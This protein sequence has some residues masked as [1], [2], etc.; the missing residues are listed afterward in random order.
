MLISTNSFLAQSDL[1]IENT[2]TVNTPTNSIPTDSRAKNLQTPPLVIKDSTQTVTVDTLDTEDSEPLE[3]PIEYNARDSIRYE[4]KGQKIFLFGDGRVKYDGMDMKAEF[5]EIDNEKN[6]LTAFGKTDSLGKETGTPVF[7]DGSQEVMA[8]KIVYNLKT[9]KGKIY[10][11]K[12]KEGELILKG[13]EVK[14]DSNNVVY[15]KN[16]ECIPCKF[17]DSRTIFKAKKAKIIPDDKIVTGP[18]YLEVGGVPTPLGLP[19]GFFPNTKKRHSG[20]LIPFYGNSDAL[21]FYLKDGGFYWGISDKTDMTIRGDIY[22]NGSWG[23]RTFNNYDI[24]YKSSG[25]VALGYSEFRSGEREIPS[26]YGKQKDISITWRHQ[27]DQKFN[28]TI[29]F[30]SDVNIRT[31]R[32]NKYNALNTGQYLT[33]TFQ[34]N[35]NFS[36]T[37]KVGVLSLNAR[38]DQNTQTKR[39]NIS[40][41]E[42]T[43]NVNRFYPFKNEKRIKQNPID[44]IGMSYLLEARNTLSGADTSIFKGNIGDSL[45]Y[46]FRHTLPISTNITLLKYFTLTPALNLSAVMYTKTTQKELDVANNRI[47]SSTN[48]NFKTGYDANFNSSLSTKLFMD[49]IFKSKQVKQ[50]RH[51]LIPTLAYTY[52]PDFGEQQYGFWKDVIT[53]TVNKLKTRY[54]IF[55]N[56]L[57]GGPGI[58]EQ[59]TLSLNLNNN[60]EAKVRK[61]TDT[62][63]VYQKITLLQ[64]LTF[65]GSYNFAA[66]SFNLSNISMTG[67]TKIWKYFDLVFGSTFDP[68][69]STILTNTLTNTEYAYRS[70]QYS[71]NVNGKLLNFYSGNIA[72]NASFSS[73]NLTMRQ[74]KPDLTNGAERQATPTNTLQAQEKLPWTLNIY[75]NINYTKVL[76]KIKDIQTLNFSGDI[77]VT[78]YWKL[79][80]TS[81]YDFTNRNLSYTSVNIYRDLKCW[82]ARIDWVPFGFRKSYNLTINLKTSMLSDVKIPRQRQW[83][84]NF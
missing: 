61:R 36:K 68:Y 49:Y 42:L 73:S 50:I 58:G 41:P 43:F 79:G 75:Y 80:L 4:T 65:N 83:Y 59:N 63:S 9:K 15:M 35:I 47:V 23:L 8:R 40:F 12:T 38:H 22:G 67:R 5:I 20:L 77:A 1:R 57:F 53:D 26:T 48:K 11:I 66:D 72:I 69:Y 16:L 29:R 19:F 18:M 37:F 10:D 6:T 21:G 44:K 17:E 55:E 32:Y 39:M 28:P 78:K 13:R 60:L 82:E 3:H 51:L 52:R 56:G 45:K 2:K 76:N 25:S 81:G 33:N 62:G 7:N 34:S 71:A 54:S 46:G 74:K 30:S 84:D 31:S 64:N 27:Q 24:N 70:S 14:K